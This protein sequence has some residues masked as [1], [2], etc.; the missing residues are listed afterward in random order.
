MRAQIGSPVFSSHEKSCWSTF[1]S[2]PSQ[3]EAEV[4]VLEGRLVVLVVV[5]ERD[6]RVVF[7][8]ACLVHASDCPGSSLGVSASDALPARDEEVSTWFVLVGVVVIAAQ[9][10]QGM[11]LRF[12][13]GE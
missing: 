5:G 13:V 9:D 6:E 8:H 4:L 11:S 12:L 7:V 3:E 1:V 10:A 2:Q